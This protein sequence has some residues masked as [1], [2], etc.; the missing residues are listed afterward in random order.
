[1]LC[2]SR[3]LQTLVAC[4]LKL[5]WVIITYSITVLWSKA[6]C[7]QG[8]KIGTVFLVWMSVMTVQAYRSVD[9]LSKENDRLS[10]SI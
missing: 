5:H 7:A 10:A 9:P 4:N 3:A 6:T 2:A 1:M 8:S